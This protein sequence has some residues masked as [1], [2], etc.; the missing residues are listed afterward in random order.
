MTGGWTPYDFDDSRGQRHRARQGVAQSLQ[1]RPPRQLAAREPM[2]M[3]VHAACAAVV[4]A[5]VEAMR[6]LERGRSGGARREVNKRN[7]GHCFGHGEPGFRLFRRRKI[8]SR[9]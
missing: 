1:P 2:G 8:Q 7:S 4:D 3:A 5:M 9:S 6:R